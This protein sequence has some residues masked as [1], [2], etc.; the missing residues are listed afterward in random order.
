MGPVYL[1]NIWLILWVNLGKYTTPMDATGKT[2]GQYLCIFTLELGNSGEEKSLL[3]N[4]NS[5][6]LSTYTP[7]N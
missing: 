7:E 5:C 3:S 2:L 1:P 6:N 4:E